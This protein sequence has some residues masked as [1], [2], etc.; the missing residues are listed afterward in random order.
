[1]VYIM[2]YEIT[3]FHKN[4][5]PVKCKAR[6]LIWESP[7]KSFSVFRIL[8]SNFFVVQINRNAPIDSLCSKIWQSKFKY[9]I[10]LLILGKVCRRNKNCKQ[11]SG[12]DKQHWAKYHHIKTQELFKYPRATKKCVFK[13]KRFFFCCFSQTKF[14][15]LPSGYLGFSGNTHVEFS[16]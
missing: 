7:T 10:L 8:K 2:V 3:A 12:F 5:A 11:L 1:M 14:P 4:T 6:N 9:N 15:V 13:R 16:K